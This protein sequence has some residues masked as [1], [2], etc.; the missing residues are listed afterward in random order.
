MDKSATKQKIYSLIL[1][2]KSLNLSKNQTIHQQLLVQ[3]SVQVT[4]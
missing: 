1:I 3:Q 4:Y 2:R